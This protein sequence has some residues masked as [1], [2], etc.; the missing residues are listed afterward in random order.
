M[1]RKTDCA[2]IIVEDN[3]VEKSSDT[4]KALINKSL[5]PALD[6]KRRLALLPVLLGVLP[7][8][9]AE[10]TCLWQGQE[11]S[12]GAELC[13]FDSAKYDEERARVLITGVKFSC[14]D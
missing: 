9:A 7:L 4:R 8:S 14:K 2:L 12:Q 5:W 11:Y 3:I 6:W 13:V 10:A 1:P